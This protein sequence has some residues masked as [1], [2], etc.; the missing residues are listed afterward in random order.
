MANP[1]NWLTGLICVT[2]LAWAEEA[3]ALAQ[4]PPQ[5]V[6]AFG[7]KMDK[8]RAAANVPL[9]DVPEKFREGVKIALEK[10]ALY[11]Q[12]PA[13]SFACAPHFY[14]WLLEHP[15]R[16]VAAWRKLGAQ[17]VMIVD[18]GAGR[19]GWTDEHG[20]DLQWET[21]YHSNDRHIWYAEG[22][23]RPAPML[24]LVP[25]KAVVVLHYREQTSATGTKLIQHQ[26]DMFL[27]TDS[28]GAALAAKLLGAAAPKMAEQCV[29][30]MQ[31]FF[32]G[33]AWYLNRHPDE[34]PS[35]LMIPGE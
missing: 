21:V 2:V 29:T 26:A 12:G 27:H 3:S 15:D 31:M 25:V 28:A 11:T 4:A 13:E 8:A 23:V 20:S 10:P 35:L 18:R 32:A 6:P 22:K 34:A 30:Q 9:Q 14:Y 24:P 19:F 16:G 17:C 5:T 1:R 33:L 7:D